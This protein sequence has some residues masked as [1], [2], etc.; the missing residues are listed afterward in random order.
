LRYVVVA[1]IVG[2]LCAGWGVVTAAA[3]VAEAAS[4][5][6]VAEDQAVFGGNR[7]LLH[8]SLNT[9]EK[10]NNKGKENVG[11]NVTHL[12]LCTSLSRVCAY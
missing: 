10:K 2:L 3:I 1:G 4:C 12:K 9:M 8:C 11:S 6:F 5:P 7:I